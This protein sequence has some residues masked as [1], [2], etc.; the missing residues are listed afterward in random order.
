MLTVGGVAML[1]IPVLSGY[2]IATRS[3]WS[4][5]SSPSDDACG[6]FAREP[7]QGRER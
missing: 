5:A 7:G 3:W 6:G 2:I 1:S 4:R